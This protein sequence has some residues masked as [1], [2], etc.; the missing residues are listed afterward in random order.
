MGLMHEQYIFLHAR[1]P[2]MCYYYYYFIFL[3]LTTAT[4]WA[5]IHT[6]NG[7]YIAAITVGQ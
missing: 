2:F 4:A 6:A 5:A 1:N 7:V 3:I